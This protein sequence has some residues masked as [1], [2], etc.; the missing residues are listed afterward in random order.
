[1]DLNVKMYLIWGERTDAP[2]T[3]RMRTFKNLA[4]LNDFLTAL[5][6]QNIRSV[7]VIS[8]IVLEDREE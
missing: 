7:K 3:Y 2:H 5:H 6:S 1:M 4:A 8:G